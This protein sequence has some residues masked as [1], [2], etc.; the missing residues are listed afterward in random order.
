MVKLAT[1]TQR[2]IEEKKQLAI[3]VVRFSFCVCHDMVEAALK[4][5]WLRQEP[6]S[7]AA[8]RQQMLR[9]RWILLDVL[10]QPDH[11]VVD[12]PRV[13]VLAQPPDLLQNGLARHDPSAV[14]DEMP[15]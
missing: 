9:M 6:V 14:A 5:R 4:A 15:Q 13:G 2:H 3:S 11:E 8:H 7:H 10:A 12:G 1:E